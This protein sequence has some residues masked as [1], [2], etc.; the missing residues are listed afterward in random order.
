MKLFIQA[1]VIILFTML[2]I[3]SLW[4]GVMYERFYSPNIGTLLA[5]DIKLLPALIFYMIYAAAL[6]IL[7]LLPSIKHQD[8]TF[9]TFLRGTLFGLVAYATYDL[10]NHATL[11]NWPLVVTLVDMVWG[12]LLTGLVTLST[13]LIL[14]KIVKE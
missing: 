2:A 11:K 8:G 6:A 14:R 7:V 5:E 1:F 4:I 3:D 13:L 12:S 9:H 10:T